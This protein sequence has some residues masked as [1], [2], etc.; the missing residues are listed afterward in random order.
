MDSIDK[1]FVWWIIFFTALSLWDLVLRGFAMWR[2]AEH[3]DRKWFIAVM[4]VSSAG[5]LPLIYLSEHS[6]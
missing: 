6:D 5:I 2:A 3:H 1:E 4:L